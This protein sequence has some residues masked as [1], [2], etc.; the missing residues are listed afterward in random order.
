MGNRGYQQ[1]PV[2]SPVVNQLEL[3]AILGELNTRDDTWLAMLLQERNTE[4]FALATEV[5]QLGSSIGPHDPSVRGSHTGTFYGTSSSYN[6]LRGL[7][8]RSCVQVST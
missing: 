5:S 8:S 4:R 2:L 1:L 7:S 6:T 3:P